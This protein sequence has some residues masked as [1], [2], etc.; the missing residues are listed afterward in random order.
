[1]GVGISGWGGGTKEKSDIAGLRWSADKFSIKWGRNT[2]QVRG[3]GVT[4]MGRNLGR[5]GN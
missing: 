3:T 4:D 1:M 5:F 2:I